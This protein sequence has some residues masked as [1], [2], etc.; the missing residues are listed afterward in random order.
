[1]VN[2]QLNVTGAGIVISK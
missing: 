1:M 2:I